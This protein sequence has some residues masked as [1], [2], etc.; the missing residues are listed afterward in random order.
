MNY[1]LLNHLVWMRD[2][3]A[4][5]ARCCKYDLERQAVLAH[6]YC[7]YQRRIDQ[8]WRKYGQYEGG[9]VIPARYRNAHEGVDRRTA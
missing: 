3:L 1:Q 6:E 2:T 9:G 7:I 8:W 4:S 5:D